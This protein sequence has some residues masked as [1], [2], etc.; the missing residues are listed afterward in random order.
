M[1]NKNLTQIVEAARKGDSEAFE[2]LYNHHA[3][4]V[5]FLALKLMKSKTDAEDITQEAFLAAF[6]NIG[7]LKEP[8]AFSAW[9]NRITVNLCTDTLKK[10]NLLTTVTLEEVAETEFI[11]ENDR[12]LLPESRLDDEETVRIIIE[13][14][15]N[16]PLPQKI[17]VYYYYYEGM[18]VREIAAQLAIQETTVRNRLA[19]ARDKIRKALEALEKDEGLKLWVAFP[20]LLVP[21]LK[22][23]MKNTQA[24]QTLLSNIVGSLSI[25]ASAATA[26]EAATAGTAAVTEA[27]TVGTAAVTEAA[28]VGTAV[29]TETATAGT[30]TAVTT[31]AMGAGKIIAACVAGVVVTTGIVTA[32][33]L[34]GGG[35]RE[36][37]PPP[38]PATNEYVGYL[39]IDLKEQ[40]I[41]DEMLA[42]MVI[43]G[44]IPQDVTNL[45]LSQNLITDISPLSE[46]VHLRNLNLNNNKIDD[47]SPLA[48]MKGLTHLDLHYNHY[49]V[50]ISPLS[51]LVNLTDLDL[52]NNQINDI[53]P[54]SGLVNLTRL[55][56]FMN[57]IEDISPLEGLVNL[58]NLSVA[59]NHH[60]TDISPL[61][62]LTNLTN[63]ALMT[64]QISDL[65]PLSGLVNL[66]YL[67]LTNNPITDASIPPLLNLV[68][69]K[70]LHLAETEITD[71]SPFSALV[72]LESLNISKNPIDESDIA[73]LQAALPE[74]LIRY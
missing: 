42:E 54:L 9:L 20:F 65:S 35:D 21:V 8:E 22:L 62:G 23:A 61:S 27:A 31:S 67:A 43:S 64:N 53:S 63:L 59:H 73:A 16:L 46:L 4:A 29:V 19:L 10:A 70:Q 57:Q 2:A 24:P 52:Y 50:D 3:Q 56:L 41:T 66:T 68:N 26:A 58:E 28:T 32:V 36:V 51:G 48:G 1:D 55:N 12:K 44:E 15:D 60:I 38:E 45:N 74:C 18:S 11:E 25:T 39:N 13:T 17:C 69:L 5:Y 30:A 37:T 40:Q 33:V 47:L 72:N 34:S 71:V 14:I 7:D 6:R 49:I